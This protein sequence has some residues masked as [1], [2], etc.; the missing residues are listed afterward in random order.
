MLKN[1]KIRNTRAY[2][3]EDFI[4]L[5][6]YYLQTKYNQSDEDKQVVA[7]EVFNILDNSPRKSRHAGWSLH[8]GRVEKCCPWPYVLSPLGHP[9]CGYRESQ[10]VWHLHQAG[11]NHTI[12]RNLN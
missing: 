12:F 5:Q 1:I 7:L 4:M 3:F 2:A 11:G 10:L 8:P 9:F 6:K